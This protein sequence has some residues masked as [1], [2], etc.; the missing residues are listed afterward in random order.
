MNTTPLISVCINCYNAEST[1]AATLRSVLTQT[2]TNLQVIV[3]DDCSTDGTWDYLQTITDPRVECHRLAQNG[4]ISNANNEALRHVRG[5]LVA[6]LDADDVWY[7]DKLAR[8][9]AFLQEHEE[10]GAC[11]TLAEMVDENGTPVEDHRFRAENRSQA[12]LL[13]HFLT[14][15]NYLC[16]SSMLARREVID[17]VGEH[18]VTLLYFHDFDYW[19]RMTMVCGI[20]I[21]PDKLLDY[22]LSTSSNSAMTKEKQMVHIYEFSRIIYQ[23]VVGCPD[24][25]FLEAFADRL[26]LREHTHTHEQVELEKAFL[27]CELLIYHPRNRALGLRRL[28]ELLADPL[29]VAVA[30]DSF[31]FTVHDL[32]TL[33][34]TTVY[35]DPLLA[36]HAAN[37]ENALQSTQEAYRIL[38]Q[39]AAALTADRDRLQEHSAILLSE[40]TALTAD[41]DRWQAHANTVTADCD[42]L[43]EHIQLLAAQLGQQEARAVNAE[44]HIALMQG[45]ISW[46]LTKP[47][48]AIKKLF[49]RH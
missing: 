32:Y 40:C 18:D 10:Y 8:Q 35:H 46:K 11:F 9:L 43:R 20:Y 15:G 2:Y 27:L 1:I 30:A 6:H 21:L 4:H 7:P 23:T 31:G 19:I 41:R 45:S 44:Q 13:H 39:H 28:C 49:R 16:H 26:R 12:A 17:R 29:Y 5:E 3:V 22:R 42:G 47:L 37:L 24:A 48:R 34:Q 14:V 25:L 33:E 38:E 36:D